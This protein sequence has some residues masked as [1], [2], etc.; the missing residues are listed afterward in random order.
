MLMAAIDPANAGEYNANAANFFNLY[1]QQTIPY[2]PRR[3]RV[4]VPL[5]SAAAHDPG[6]YIP[7]A[8]S[9]AQLANRD[10]AASTWHVCLAEHA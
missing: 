7:Q 9:R 1:L 8:L 10:K 4:P 2:T 3:P 5:G 6:T